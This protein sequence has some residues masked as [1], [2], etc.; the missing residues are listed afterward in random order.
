MRVDIA[1]NDKAF[2]NRAA[3]AR[4]YT[5]A[6][7]D[8]ATAEERLAARRSMAQNKISTAANGPTGTVTNA[9][10]RDLRMLE[11]FEKRL[12][13]IQRQY[14]NLRTRGN[15]N[16]GNYTNQ[17]VGVEGQFNA[18]SDLLG[19]K[20]ITRT[21]LNGAFDGLSKAMHALK[22]ETDATD[23]A[24]KRAGRTYDELMAKAR[25]YTRETSM[26]REGRLRRGASRLGVPADTLG[27][28]SAAQAQH[29]LEQATLKAYSAK[30]RLNAALASD[31]GAQKIA[32][33]TALYEGYEKRLVHA[34]ALQNQLNRTQ[35]GGGGGSDRGLFGISG[36]FGGAMARTGVYAAAGA[37]VYALVNTLQ[38]GAR[39]AVEFEDKLANLQAIAGATSGQM[40]GL[41]DTIYDVGQNSKHSL[42][43]IAEA[44]TTLAQAGFGVKDMQ[45]ALGS[46][47]TLAAA[48]G[49]GMSESVDLVTS[50][51]GA[52]QLQA[53]E[54]PMLV[55]SL[56]SALNRSKLGVQQVAAG[57]QYVGA[58]ANDNNITFQELTASLGALANAGVRGSTAATGTRQFLVDLIDPSEKLQAALKAVGLTTADVDVKTRGF[59][60]VLQTLKDAGFDSAEAYSALETRSAAAYL[61]LKENIPVIQDL[62]LAQQDHGAAMHAEEAA[63]GSLSAQ[64]QRF[65]NVAGAG[66][67]DI[68]VPANP[69]E[70]GFWEATLRTISD[71]Y[72]RTARSAQELRDLEDGLTEAAKKQ[73]EYTI[74]QREEARKLQDE[75]RWFAAWAK[76]QRATQ[77]MPGLT[78]GKDGEVNQIIDQRHEIMALADAHADLETQV[79]ATNEELANNWQTI[80][81]VD[82]AINKLLTQQDRYTSNSVEL[83]TETGVLTGRFQGLAAQL[84]TTENNFYGLINALQLYR[85]EAYAAAQQTLE[86]QLVQQRQQ[87]QQNTQNVA[88]FNRRV[89]SGEV[90]LSGNLGK[91]YW[92]A[93][94][95]GDPAAWRRWAMYA[96]D[97]KTGVKGTGAGS[98]LSVAGDIVGGQNLS[99][100]MRQTQ[101]S[102]AQV[103]FYQTPVGRRS[104]ARRDA[105][106]VY[107][108]NPKA[109]TELYGSQSPIDYGNKYV[110]ELDKRIAR[111]PDPATRGIL[112]NERNDW[113][114]VVDQAQGHD[115]PTEDKKKSGSPKSDRPKRKTKTDSQRSGERELRRRQR[116]ALDVAQATFKN[117]DMDLD[118]TIEKFSEP[119]DL[120]AFE[121]GAVEVL[122]ALNDWVVQ[123]EILTAKE[124]EQ[125][126]LKGQEAE[127]YKREMAKE[128]ER[129]AR[130]IRSTL[131]GAALDMFDNMLEASERAAEEI[132]RPFKYQLAVME[133]RV[134]S[135]DRLGVD[136]RTPDYVRSY[137]G[138]RKQEYQETT[139]ARQVVVN[140]GQIRENML[141]EQSL[142]AMLTKLASQW[143]LDPKALQ[144]AIDDPDQPLGADGSIVTVAALEKD[145]PGISAFLGNKENKEL[146]DRM[147][148]HRKATAELT[149]ETDGLAESLKGAQYLPQNLG[150][151]F[152]MASE[153]FAYSQGLM[154][155]W[156]EQ[157]MMNFGPAL[158]ETHGNLTEFFDAFIENPMK[159]LSSFGAFVEGILSMLRRMASEMLANEAMK[160]LIGLGKSAFGS[161][162]AG[163]SITSAIGN[164]AGKNLDPSSALTAA[165]GGKQS[166]VDVAYLASATKLSGSALALTQSAVALNQAALALG[167]GGGSGASSIFSA[168]A[169]A[170]S[171]YAGGGGKTEG[172]TSAFKAVLGR[173][174]GGEVVAGFPSHDSVLTNLTR[175]EHVLQRSAVRSL[176]KG[177]LDDLNARG[178]R[179]LKGI[180]GTAVLPAPA[181]QETNVWVVSN[182][183]PQ[184]GPND[185]LAVIGQDI[186]KGGRTKE[187]IKSVAQ[188]G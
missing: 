179:A 143:G 169:S 121:D 162:D 7:K 149:A 22:T 172:L 117:S 35:A 23:A 50:A 124:I 71:S 32:R 133:G 24:L 185:V 127:V 105:A 125:K 113:A 108:T 187:L 186:A 122:K 132:M 9:M 61:A 174:K 8:A 85:Q 102:I 28:T 78:G 130:E 167:V 45:E 138:R 163:K 43:D 57:L 44:A 5:R 155:T 146:L 18:L 84:L 91:S 4:E 19:K 67:S 177:F 86:L 109:W 176:P 21:D 68:F 95:S 88:D 142:N 158:T 171:A 134:S 181:R 82:D 14:Q 51:L 140:R 152:K 72:E 64:W 73:L 29:R 59:V 104:L 103:Q 54:T 112:Q 141:A 20:K 153:D 157:L 99:A 46:V 150:Q 15:I 166:G 69:A 13:G 62:I 154:R 10:T 12:A 164:L 36:G 31:A 156:E 114:G 26:E 34:I 76:E 60:P 49:T 98:V 137:Y 97:P 111:E 40:R 38:D 180:G 30:T 151:A 136:Y 118:E 89:D 11:E 173:N 129:K 183:P 178:A 47:A 148:A 83:Q 66:L 33:L 123:K 120:S 96:S 106:S 116:S 55:D 161:P 3:A 37:S 170:L 16:G 165:F 160:Q 79:A 2:A 70:M 168:G 100:G 101:Q 58:T 110:A 131:F 188:G 52:F 119:M 175:G 74:A 94:K 135:F 90:V 87:H 65:K 6:L 41:A 92:A 17:I 81:G 77:L 25:Q 39:F 75:G 184:M 182:P 53:S 159:A 48:S 144:A 93:R 126:G 139:D 27:T 42:I 145:M 56:V 1:N 80:G 147:Y 128:T 107:K 63:M 115:T